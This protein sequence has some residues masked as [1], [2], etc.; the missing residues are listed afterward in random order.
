MLLVCIFICIFLSFLLSSHDKTVT[1]IFVRMCVFTYGVA[2]VSR[3][4]KIIGH[5]CRI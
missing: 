5:F 1:R 3:I 2:T 4:D